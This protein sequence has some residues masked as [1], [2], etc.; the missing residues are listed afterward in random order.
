ML[1]IH[2]NYGPTDYRNKVISLILKALITGI[3]VP[4]SDGFQEL[5]LLFIDDIL[6]AYIWAGFKQK[7][8]NLFINIMML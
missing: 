3:D 2:D 8:K 7:R 1:R 4:L 6:D 5:D